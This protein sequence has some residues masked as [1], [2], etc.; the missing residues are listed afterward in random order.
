VYFVPWQEVVGVFVPFSVRRF[1]WIINKLFYFL[2]RFNNDQD[3]V[4]LQFPLRKNK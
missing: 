3:S 2:G 1:N 4:V